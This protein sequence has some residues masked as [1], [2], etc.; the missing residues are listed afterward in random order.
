MST[1]LHLDLSLQAEIITV[2]HACLCVR[3]ETCSSFA[4]ELTEPLRELEASVLRGK[5][6]GAGESDRDEAGGGVELVELPCAA[7]WHH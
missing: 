7:S 5:V 6:L 4:R 2:E 3:H 1:G